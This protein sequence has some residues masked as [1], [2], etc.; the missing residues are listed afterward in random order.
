MAIIET[1]HSA[2]FERSEQ[3]ILIKLTAD[4]GPDGGFGSRDLVVTH[5]SVQVREPNGAL[6]FQMPIAEIQ[7]ARNEP[8][9]GGGRL[10]ITAKNGDILPVVTYSQ[11]VAA[12]FSEAARGIEQLA[13]NEP[14]Q[15]NLT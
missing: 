1:Q 4:F 11:T 8:L 10:E 2:P 5:E 6:A 13:K 15:I 3:E 14:F 7:T 9:V 12:R